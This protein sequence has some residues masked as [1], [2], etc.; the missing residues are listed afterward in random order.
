MRI[1]M[2]I[3]IRI[4]EAEKGGGLWLVVYSSKFTAV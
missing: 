4:I 1:T 3:Y 2:F